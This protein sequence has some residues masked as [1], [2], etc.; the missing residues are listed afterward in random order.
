MSIKIE[1]PVFLKRFVGGNR[2]IK[3]SPGKLDDIFSYIKKI[4]PD[5]SKKIFKDDNQLKSF[6][7]LS[8]DNKVIEKDKIEKIEVD[9]DQVIK[10]VMAVGGG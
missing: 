3:S 9:D 10:I 1:F 5:F 8:L 2:Y 7:I 6:I 4:Y